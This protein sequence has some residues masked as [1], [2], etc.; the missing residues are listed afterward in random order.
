MKLWIVSFLLLFFAAETAQWLGQLPWLN[1]LELSTP[2]T[3][4]GG[5]GLAIASNSSH[6]SKRPLPDSGVTA[7]KPPEAPPTPQLGA[8]SPA[9]QPTVGRQANTISFEIKKAGQKHL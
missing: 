6:R 7:P 1:G 5:V 3:I 4:L 9:P 2:L 8:P